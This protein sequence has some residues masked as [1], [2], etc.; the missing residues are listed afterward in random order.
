MPAGHSEKDQRSETKPKMFNLQAPSVA[1][2]HRVL[3]DGPEPAVFQFVNGARR[4]PGRGRDAV[5]QN[6][7]MFLR[8]HRVQRRPEHRVVH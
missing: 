8:F 1:R 7:R 6:R 5:P 2:P 4:R 3:D